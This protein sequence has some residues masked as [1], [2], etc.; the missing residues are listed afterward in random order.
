MYYRKR[1]AEEKLLRLKSYFKVVLVTGARQVGKSTL[2]THLFPEVKII[3]FDPVQDLFGARQDPDLFLDN[4]PPPL[5]LDEIQFV[6]ELLPALKRRVDR[7]DSPGQYILTGSQNL[8]ML[9]SVAESMAGRVAI[10]PLQSMTAY[11]L[12]GWGSQDGWLPAYLDDPDSLEGLVDGAMDQLGNLAR[13]LWRGSLPGLLDSP[14]EIVPDYFSAYIQTYV[15][16]DIR[17]MEDIRELSAFGRFLGLAGALTAQEVNASQFGR[18]VGVTPATAR[19][20]LDL[21]TN[22]Y[23]WLEL[24]PYQGN[25][26]KRLSGKRKGFLR[27]TGMGCYLQR[28]SSP[29]ALAVSP[30]LGPM[31]ETWAVNEVLRQGSTLAMPPQAYHWRTGGGAEVDLVLERD[32]RLYPIELKCKSNVTGH[33]VRGL[34]AFRETY[35]KEKIMTGLVV[36]AGKDSYRVDDHTM[37]IPW[38]LKLRGAHE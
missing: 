8:S 36:Y 26:V 2:L 30:M 17:L 6:P 18:D 25:T 22:T 21:L 5:I 20:W 38:N 13:F 19:K 3:V 28:I 34:R 24:F 15:E 4:F 31:F 10:L 12:S 9:R 1:Q 35:P 27:D 14:D 32:G 37:A 29:D 11:E 7:L 16:R 33:D 23:Q